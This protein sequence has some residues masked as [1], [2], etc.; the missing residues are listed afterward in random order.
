MNPQMK[1]IYIQV[2]TMT[3]RVFLLLLPFA[4]Y[5]VAFPLP[6]DHG[7][8]FYMSGVP[9]AV[10]VLNFIIILSLTVDQANGTVEGD[11]HNMYISGVPAAVSLLSLPIVLTPRMDQINRTIVENTLELKATSKDYARDFYILDIPATVSMIISSQQLIKSEMAQ[12][13]S[14]NTAETFEE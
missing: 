10:S 2:Y 6:G 8:D 5:L 14:D 13:N 9:I 7:R 11:I 4:K 3:F 1:E 12:T